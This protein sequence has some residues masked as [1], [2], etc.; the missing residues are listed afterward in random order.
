MDV[1]MSDKQALVAPPQPA[2][3]SVDKRPTNIPDYFIQ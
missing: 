2:S 1:K 3:T